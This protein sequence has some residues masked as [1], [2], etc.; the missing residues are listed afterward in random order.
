M[1]V[2]DASLHLLRV[3]INPSG[4]AVLVASLSD[5]RFE[6]EKA[7][8]Q[9]W[10]AKEIFDSFFRIPIT[11]I[12]EQIHKRFLSV[13]LVIF[14][15][16]FFLKD[17]VVYLLIFFNRKNIFDQFLR[18]KVEFEELAHLSQDSSFNHDYTLGKFRSY[19]RIFWRS[20]SFSFL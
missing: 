15:E 12:L 2:G 14:V 18:F 5:N 7:L 10:V 9:P 3:R 8:E 16:N 13:W 11:D 20:A 1:L 6:N 17:H 4:I 19:S